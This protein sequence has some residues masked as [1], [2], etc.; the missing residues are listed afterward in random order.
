LRIRPSLVKKPHESIVEDFQSIKD[1]EPYLDPSLK[2][3]LEAPVTD[4]PEHKSRFFT[5]L[6]TLAAKNADN[7]TYKTRH[8]YM[9]EGYAFKIR[10]ADNYYVV[11]VLR[12]D[13]NSIPG[14]D[15]QRLILFDPNGRVLDKLSCEINSRLSRMYSNSGQFCT[16]VLDGT[17]NS[18]AQLAIRYI[19]EKGGSVSGNWSHEIIS[20][21]KTYSFHWDQDAPNNIRSSEWKSKGLCRVAIRAGKFS[22]VFPELRKPLSND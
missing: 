18:D 16:D 6:A 12:G 3:L 19:P 10:I 7:F 8:W 15:A 21:G 20:H 13:T 17:K 14:I 2:V 9:D 11:A 1:E 22:V 5:S 4:D